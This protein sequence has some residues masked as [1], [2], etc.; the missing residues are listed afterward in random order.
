MNKNYK[1][2]KQLFIPIFL[3]IFFLNLVGSVDTMMLSSLNDNAVGGVGTSN[4]YMGVFTI[5]FSVISSGMIAVMTQYI[6]VGKPGVARQ[7]VKIGGLFN[8]V[9]G[10]IVSV[11]LFLY[12]EPILILLGISSA[13]FE[14]AA[15]YTKIVG[16]ACI[17]NAII[18]IVNC[19]LRAFGHSVG[20][21]VA[22]IVGNVVNLVL[23]ALF[24]FVFDMGVMGVAIATVIS[25]VVN[26]IILLIM[27]F[28][29]IKI[30]KDAETIE[31]GT[32][33]KQ[34]ISIGFPAAMETALYNLAMTIVMSLLNRMDEDGFNVTVKSYAN[35]IANYSYIA[36]LAMAQANAIITGWKIGEKKYDECLKDTI[37]TSVYGI[38]VAVIISLIFVFSSPFIMIFFTDNKEM[39]SVIQKVLIIDAFLE[40]GRVANLVY[41]TALKTCGDAIYTVT[42]AVIFMYLFAVFGTYL[43]GIKLELLVIGCWIG[44]ALD[45]C[46]RAI[47][48]FN[49][50]KSK[51]WESKVLIK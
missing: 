41:G 46:A 8:G 44:L 15:V 9:M 50:W 11:V 49:R 27:S 18:P 7:A 25:R 32:V 21:L 31:T 22:T 34:I 26:F 3:E 45:E 40:I 14:H 29:Y 13:L 47:L 36:G 43:F 12:S 24:L 17:L 38:R 2:L 10:L 4:T 16:G 1:T 35:L 19:Y 51:K 33:V 48:M 39:I 6:G 30:P 20:P 42:I 28:L 37:K 23:N 5:S